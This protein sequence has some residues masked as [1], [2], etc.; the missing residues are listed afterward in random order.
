MRGLKSFVGSVSST[1]ILKTDPKRFSNIAEEESPNSVLD[2]EN[3][4]EASDGSTLHMESDLGAS[5]FVDKLSNASKKFYGANKQ[6]ISVGKHLASTTTDKYVGVQLAHG[7]ESLSNWNEVLSAESKKLLPTHLNNRIKTW[8]IIKY[9]KMMKYTMQSGSFLLAGLKSAAQLE[10]E[11]L[12]QVSNCLTTIHL[13]T[14]V[15][16]A[17]V[18]KTMREAVTQVMAAWDSFPLSLINGLD[19]E[20]LRVAT[21]QIG[22]VAGVIESARAGEEKTTI[23]TLKGTKYVV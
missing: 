6:L 22:A 4:K 9:V 11:V 13:I 8:T 17:I 21:K 5:G 12:K 1:S 16:I 3:K 15:Q 7:H 19:I 20:Q 23:V 18:A 14:V 2:A 10:G